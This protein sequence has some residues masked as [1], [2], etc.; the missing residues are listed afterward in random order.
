MAAPTLDLICVSYLAT[1]D[2]LRVASHPPRNHGAEVLERIRS[3]AGDGTIAA[4]TASALGLRAGLVANPIGVDA[5]GSAL[6]RHLE[7][8]GVC[9]ANAQADSAVT[10]FLAV[11][12]DHDGFRTWLAWVPR[13]AVDGLGRAG[14]AVMPRARLA[15]IDCYAIVGEAAVRAVE[16]AARLRMP[17][18]LNLGGDPL[19]GPIADAAADGQV[20]AVQTSV[21]VA[22]GEPDEVL[23]R[24]HETAE[25]LFDQLR[26]SAAVVT[27]GRYG[28]V[29]RTAEGPYASA[30]DEAPVQFVHGAGEAFS[31]GFAAALLD[32]Q[33]VRAALADGCAVG[34][35]HCQGS[36][37]AH[38]IGAPPRRWSL[39]PAGAQMG[40]GR[41]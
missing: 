21:D 24:A 7:T 8:W 2:I 32:G 31:A 34:A 33:H 41:R 27:I 25:L 22:E 37:E 16:T 23:L 5:A 9:L 10:P 40:E 15:Y 28:A 26:P 18:L 14:W 1:A 13:S 36:I 12:D 11:I 39:A 35:A 38:R 19:T 4:L 6:V 3:T 17:M 29:A 30:A 20:F